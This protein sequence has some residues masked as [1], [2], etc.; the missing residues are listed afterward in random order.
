MNFHRLVHRSRV[1]IVLLVCAGIVLNGCQ[2]STVIST[3]EAVVSSAEIAL[4]VIGAAVGLS[5]Q[6]SA[7]IVQYLQAVDAAVIQAS[8]ILSGPGTSADKATRI[9][10][11][12]VS[13]AQGCNCV[14]AGTPTAVVQVVDA[15]VKA[16][17]RFLTNVTPP[18]GPSAR[19]AV[20]IKVSR[21]DRAALT[22]IRNRAE[23]QL[24]KLK[25]ARP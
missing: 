18:S 14:P 1:G 7:Q 10:Q 2:P 22:D 11:A 24:T 6:V 16:I 20:T 25:G 19:A 12:F 21:S 23:Q 13:V 4:P 17:A 15:V 9:A 8:G 5:P 3:L